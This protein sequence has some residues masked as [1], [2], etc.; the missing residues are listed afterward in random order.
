MGKAKVSVDQAAASFSKTREDTKS[1]VLYVD[2][3]GWEALVP[4]ETF[5]TLEGPRMMGVFR[6]FIIIHVKGFPE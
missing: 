4:E 5:V 1:Y 3:E 2:D 6:G